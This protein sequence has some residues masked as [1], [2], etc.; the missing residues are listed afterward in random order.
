MPELISRDD[1]LIPPPSLQP[2]L[3]PAPA[4][5]D[6]PS[7]PGQAVNL[8]QPPVIE[9]FVFESP[10]DPALLTGAPEI[11]QG[12]VPIAPV[13]ADN[14]VVVQPQS[15]S[16]PTSVPR[17]D[18][19]PQ[20]VPFQP[21]QASLEELQEAKTLLEMVGQISGDAQIQSIENKAK[22]QDDTAALQSAGLL[23]A[24]ASGVSNRN[25]DVPLSLL[26]DKGLSVTRQKPTPIQDPVAK[27]RKSARLLIKRRFLNNR[28]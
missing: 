7:L 3:L 2:P 16:L 6:I 4:F 22:F 25:G 23:S 21:P 9:P 13:I 11:P 28:V 5:D 10:L 12:V 14:P 17:F 26:S 20:A 24:S 1:F 18:A 27:F 19:G 8:F 15:F